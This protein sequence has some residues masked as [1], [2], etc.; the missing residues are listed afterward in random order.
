MHA[1]ADEACAR[2]NV[3]LMHAAA[4]RACQDACHPDACCWQGCQCRRAVW[5]AVLLWRP[6]WAKLHAGAVAGTALF[7]TLPPPLLAPLL[8]A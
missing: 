4:D 2:V 1:V 8:H 3:S 7:D 6:V 5:G